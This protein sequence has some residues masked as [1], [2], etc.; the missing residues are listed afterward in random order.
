MA[1]NSAAYV[2][3]DVAAFALKVQSPLSGALRNG[4]H[5]SITY[6]R[7]LDALFIRTLQCLSKCQFFL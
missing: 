4:K 1:F 2:Y 5:F 7:F 3:L 6:Y